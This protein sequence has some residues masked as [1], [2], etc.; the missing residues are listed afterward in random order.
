MSQLLVRPHEP[1]AAGCVL[2]VT[3]HTAGWKCIC[4]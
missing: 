3:P 2:E 4:G 1:D